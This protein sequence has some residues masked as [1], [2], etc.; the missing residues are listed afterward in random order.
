MKTSRNS[1]KE[2]ASSV[3]NRPSGQKREKRSNSE[4]MGFA[5]SLN[6][7]DIRVAFSEFRDTNCKD[8]DNTYKRLILTT[9]TFL[10]TSA[11]CDRGFVHV[12][13]LL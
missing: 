7:L 6:F 13:K 3:T 5:S 11:E 10:L 1:A 4:H 12:I 9:N 8:K 2:D